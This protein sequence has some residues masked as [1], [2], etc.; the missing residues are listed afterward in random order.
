MKIASQTAL[1]V[2]MMILVLLI[3]SSA[4]RAQ[5]G[6]DYAIRRSVIATGGNGVGNTDYRMAGSSGQA[7]AGVIGGG[8]Y[9]L[10]GGFWREASP[11]ALPDPLHTDGFED[12]R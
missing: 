2:L 7:L 10:Q 9:R 5:S 6:G 8:D 1:G 11:T 3:A 12:Q 4:G